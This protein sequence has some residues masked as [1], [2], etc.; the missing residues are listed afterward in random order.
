MPNFVKVRF[1]VLDLF[2]TNTETWGAN[3]KVFAHFRHEHARN[4]V[5]KVIKTGLN[6]T[7]GI[8]YLITD[9]SNIIFYILFGL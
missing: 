5:L 9:E 7:D 2:R 3:R 8:Q 4:V 6:V 1:A